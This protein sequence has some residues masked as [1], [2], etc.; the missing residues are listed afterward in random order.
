MTESA[1]EFVRVVHVVSCLI[2]KMKRRIE[3][4]IKHVLAVVLTLSL[5]SLASAG[6]QEKFDGFSDGD[7]P[8]QGAWLGGRLFGDHPPAVIG[9][10]GLNN[11]K[12]AGNTADGTSNRMGGDP[13][14]PR[15]RPLR[16]HLHALRRPDYPR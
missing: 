6:F 11:S 13:A 12:G 2:S 3:M 9:D 8:G 7:L 5:T 1:G 15:G 10:V 4:S 14:Q 16:R